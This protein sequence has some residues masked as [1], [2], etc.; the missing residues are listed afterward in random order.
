MKLP[1]R[2]FLGCSVSGISAL[3][4]LLSTTSCSGAAIEAQSMGEAKFVDVDGIR[5]RYFEGGSGE[6]MLLVHGGHFGSES[7]AV[8]WM[9]VF[10]N[11]AAHFHMYAID[12]LGMGLTENP[13]DDEG[14]LMQATVQ[15]LYRFLETTG[16]DQVHLVG[17]SRGALPV[18]S[19]AVNHPR[20]VKTLTIF[21]SNTLAPVD[22]PLSSPNVS[23]PGPPPT[24]ESIREQ[25]LSSET[26]FHE[27]FIT[28]EYVEAELEVALSPKIREAEERMEVL[29]KRFIEN[30]PEKMEA[31]P[32]LANNSGTGWW[33]YETKDETLDM[34]RA[35]RL[36]IPTHV[37][38]EFNDPSA[39]YP[40]GD[41]PFFN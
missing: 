38:W 10:P 20:L 24:K 14:Y 18:A 9:P 26:T 37:I 11:L 25:L 2:D 29:R 33:L 23:R 12:K 32:A 16:I 6:A 13:A 1:R 30:N 31:R 4:L 19:I 15:H 35:G 27:D 22:P 28:D 7:S 3:A 21:D 36:Q 5:T 17:H 8:G 34:L 40:D 39:T 41:G